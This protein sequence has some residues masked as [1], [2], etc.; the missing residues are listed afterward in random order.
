MGLRGAARIPASRAP[1]PFRAMALA[2][3]AAPQK[4]PAIL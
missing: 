1:F 3:D 2:S 4:N